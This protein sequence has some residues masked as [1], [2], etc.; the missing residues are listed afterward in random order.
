M[1]LSSN[2]VVDS[3]NGS[4]TEKDLLKELNAVANN[5]HKG[6]STNGSTTNKKQMNAE[7]S[8]EGA[9]GKFQVT[10]ACRDCGG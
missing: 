4:L 10:T 1:A 5:E 7:T 6:S 2:G 9:N 3:G 8:G